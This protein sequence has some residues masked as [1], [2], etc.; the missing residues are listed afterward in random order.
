MLGP[1]QLTP[2]FPV[3]LWFSETRAGCVS[4]TCQAWCEGSMLKIPV[5]SA[6]TR[7]HVEFDPVVCRVTLN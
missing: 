3:L 5:H 6:H 2:I 1:Q 4:C 7:A